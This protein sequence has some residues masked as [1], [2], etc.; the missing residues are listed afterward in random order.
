[1]SLGWA[2]AEINRFD[3]LF[4][5]LVELHPTPPTE[6]IV[7]PLLIICVI[8]EF[9]ISVFSGCWQAICLCYLHDPGYYID[10]H[11]F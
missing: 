10:E 11:T 9:D 7:A 3:I 5:Q 6:C 1:M 4:R 2:Q 8:K